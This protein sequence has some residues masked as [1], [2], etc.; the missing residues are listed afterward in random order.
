MSFKWADHIAAANSRK[1][2]KDWLTD[3]LRWAECR[4]TCTAQK[5]IL[6]P[7]LQQ[8]LAMLLLK[9]PNAVERADWP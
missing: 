5:P 4:A 6:T 9:C 8:M 1:F 7:S 2:T 3:T